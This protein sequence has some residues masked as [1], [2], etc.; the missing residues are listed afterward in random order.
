MDR[1]S[2]LGLLALTLAGGLLGSLGI[3]ALLRLQRL[4]LLVAGWKWWGMVLYSVAVGAVIAGIVVWVY[5]TALRSG[6]L[7]GSIGSPW[8]FFAVGLAAGLPFSTLSVLAVRRR[9]KQAEDRRHKRQEKPAS[10]R[11]RLE[12]ASDLERQLRDYSE[13]LRDA[14]VVLRG[15]KGSVVAISGNIT[16]EQA[17]RLVAVLRGEL[18]DLGIQRV[19]SGES[20]K[21]WWVR[22]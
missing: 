21:R 3:P 20:G 6:A 11:E 4:R 9:A 5:R 15:E 12:F 1:T 7:D 16:R 19:E 10:R 22:V 2:I 17:E 14:R 13:D 8:L 18:Q